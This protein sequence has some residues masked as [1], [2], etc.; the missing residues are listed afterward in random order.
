[1]AYMEIVYHAIEM[2][3]DNNS[4]YRNHRNV[5]EIRS[6]TK[7]YYDDLSSVVVN[8][9]LYTCIIN[10][11]NNEQVQIILSTKDLFV[12]DETNIVVTGW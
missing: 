1:M 7:R 12:R 9:N 4:S 11:Y 6:N 8:C 10:S 3:I 2:V 5:Y